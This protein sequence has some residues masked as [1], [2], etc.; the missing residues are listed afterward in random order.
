ML[1]IAQTS[2]K[3]CPVRARGDGEVSTCVSA[4]ETTDPRVQ[5]GKGE[6]MVTMHLHAL[7][8]LHVDGQGDGDRL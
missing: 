1:R 5:P 6:N 8:R 7:V 2:D 3:T 4:Y